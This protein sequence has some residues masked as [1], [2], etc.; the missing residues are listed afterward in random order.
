[1]A[2]TESAAL[3]KVFFA[4]SDPTRRAIIRQLAKGEATVGQLAAP[5]AL[6]PATMS[7]HL[8]VLARSGLIRRERDGRFLR[9]RLNPGPLRSSR[10]W[11]DETRQLWDV[12]LDALE[13]LLKR[14]R[15]RA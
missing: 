10:D 5:F 8:G 12:Q 4:L 3:D 2:S 14:E 1:M 11:L 9:S 6:A 15:G 7:K 13:A